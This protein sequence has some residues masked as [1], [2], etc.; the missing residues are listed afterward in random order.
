MD[1]GDE[2]EN[3]DSRI[4]ESQRANYVEEGEDVA[5]AKVDVMG[6]CQVNALS[7]EKEVEGA[8]EV[9]GRKRWV[10][11]VGRGLLGALEAK[12]LGKAPRTRIQGVED[13]R[14]FAWDESSKLSSG[15]TACRH[16]KLWSSSAHTSS[17]LGT[18]WQTRLPVTSSACDRVT[19]TG[20][21]EALYM[22]SVR[23]PC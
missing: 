1:D 18:K 16:M 22:F 14:H 13:S 4:V 21:L 15:L 17:L 3:E 7:A 2:G 12:W 5:A 20:S 23:R 6:C 19:T 9:E 10:W 11:E 8:K